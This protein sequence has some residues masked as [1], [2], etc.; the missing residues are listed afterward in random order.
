[1]QHSHRRGGGVGGVVKFGCVPR[2]LFRKQAATCS[3][4]CSKPLVF[5]SSWSRS[6]W[7]RWFSWGKDMKNQKW[8]SA[9][10]CKARWLCA[11]DVSHLFGSSKEK[12]ASRRQEVFRVHRRCFSLKPVQQVPHNDPPA[13]SDDPSSLWYNVHTHSLCALCHKDTRGDETHARRIPI[14]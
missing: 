4:S 9:L 12:K 3:K 1:M 10:P 2:T 7:C 14:D 13:Q 8:S 11:I 5:G 6:S